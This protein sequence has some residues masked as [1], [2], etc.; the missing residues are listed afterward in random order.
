MDDSESLPVPST[1]TAEQKLARL[2]AENAWLRGR[3]EGLER[4][5]GLSSRN[6]GKPPSSD[7]LR[8][9][10]A[11]RRTRSL[12]GRSG[13]KPGGQPGHKGET[14][15]RTAHPDRVQAPVP[16]ACKGCGSS[17]SGSDMTGAPGRSSGL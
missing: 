15:R 14:L 16:A 11:T 12:R 2:A 6:R 1:E 17:L 9:P 7:G 3:I 4:R 10:R 13:R 5:L 8:K